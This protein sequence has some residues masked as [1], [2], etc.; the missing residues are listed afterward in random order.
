MLDLGDGQ[1]IW[2]LASLSALAFIARLIQRSFR[3]TLGCSA[4]LSRPKLNL[5][6]TVSVTIVKA[7]HEKTAPGVGL[8]TKMTKEN[9]FE[10]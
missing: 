10:V 5:E 2:R 4:I 1:R 8:A 9:L 6:R 3:A 7:M